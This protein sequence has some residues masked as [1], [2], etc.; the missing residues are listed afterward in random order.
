[1]KCLRHSY[2]AVS[3]IV[4]VL[5]VGAAFAV[6]SPAHAFHHAHHNTSIHAGLLC[7]WMCTAGQ[8]TEAAETILETPVSII[9]IL[10]NLISN[11]TIK[12]PV[13]G[14]PSRGPPIL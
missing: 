9:G 12:T 7:S 14:F 2:I 11:L 6:Q 10:E 13:Q 1:M 8:V 5:F 3:L 4:C